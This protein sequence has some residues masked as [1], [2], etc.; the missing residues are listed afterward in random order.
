MDSSDVQKDK[1]YCIF[2]N[3]NEKEQIFHDLLFF[4]VFP[5]FF[6]EKIRHTLSDMYPSAL[7]ITELQYSDHFVHILKNCEG[8][9]FYFLKG[10]NH[11]FL[12]FSFKKEGIICFSLL[13]ILKWYFLCL[14]YRH[15]DHLSNFLIS[16]SFTLF[17]EHGKLDVCYIFI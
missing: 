15:F 14:Y 2:L 11:L 7:S 10:K 3:S 13:L 16:L 8:G 5:E 17:E 6:E 4:L 12:I 1:S 9:E